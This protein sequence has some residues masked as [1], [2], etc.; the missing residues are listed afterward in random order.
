MN[1]KSLLQRTWDFLGIPFRLIFFD[2]KWLPYFGWTTL[3]EERLKAVLPYIK[4]R[5]LD[6]GAGSNNLVKRYGKGFGVDVHDWG[7]GVIVVEDTSHL[8][9]DE[10][11]FD[12]ITFIACLN[13]IPYRQAVLEEA[14]RLLKPDGQLIITM[15]NP[16]FGDIGHVI[17]WYGE[18]RHRGGMEEG[19]VG[20]LWKK[21]LVKMCQD[22]GFDLHVHQRFV[23]Y[24]NNLYIFRLRV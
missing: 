16:F 10:Q 3:E 8:P 24:M 6:I 13:H 12:T 18:D 11:S 21:E 1:D 7:G 20:G 14:R 4:G 17:W 2:Q 5:L 15:I 19:E 23:Y 9:F 22:A